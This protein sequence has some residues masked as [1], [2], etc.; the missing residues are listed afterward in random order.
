LEN[1][2]S[3]EKTMGSP[4]TGLPQIWFGFARSFSPDSFDS[5]NG[6]HAQE[7]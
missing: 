3:F 2:E 1:A 7:A 5:S 6:V 4:E